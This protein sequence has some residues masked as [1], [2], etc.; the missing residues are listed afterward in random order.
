MTK[1]LQPIFEN[2]PTCESFADVGCDHGFIAEQMIKS[3]KCSNV[4]VSDISFDSL[5]KAKKLL[6]KYIDSGLAFAICTDGLK[7]I[8]ENTECVLIAG[9]SGEEIIKIL[10]SS[11]FLPKTLVLQPMKNTDKVRKAL[12]LLGYGIKKDYI[13]YDKDKYYNLLVC[14]LDEKCE[15]YS[16]L[17]LFF[18]RD[19]LVTRSEDFINYLKKEI[20][21]VEGYLSKV[22]SVEEIQSI[23][24]KINLLKGVLYGN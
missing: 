8:N 5:N 3:G 10:N 19:N 14:S 21:T 12:F 15:E 7:G 4:T 16:E 2:I 18:G 11:T 6:K 22:R 13:F 20:S 24:Q 17:E 9:M 1:R 23:Q